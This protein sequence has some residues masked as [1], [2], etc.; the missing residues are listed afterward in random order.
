MPPGDGQGNAGE[1]TSGAWVSVAEA[2]RRLGVTPRAVRNRIERDTIVWPEF[3]VCGER[4]GIAARTQALARRP[5]SACAYRWGVPGG[6]A[7]GEDRLGRRN[8]ELP[9][10]V[11]ELGTDG[12]RSEERRVG[13]ERRSRWSG[14]Q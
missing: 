2:A 10:D 11:G 9:E 1:A 14:A 6:S 3:A 13:K 7:D 4:A 8:L 12:R 5:R